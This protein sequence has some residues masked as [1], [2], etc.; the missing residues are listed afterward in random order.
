MGCSKLYLIRKWQGPL[1]KHFLLIIYK[2]SLTLLHVTVKLQVKFCVRW[3]QWYASV[4]IQFIMYMRWW[5]C[6]SCETYER[7][8]CTWAVNI[9]CFASYRSAYTNMEE[10]IDEL[11][12]EVENK[13]INKSN[14]DRSRKLQAANTSSSKSSFR[15]S[16]WVDHNSTYR[17]VEAG[18][19]RFAFSGPRLSI[20]N[21]FIRHPNIWLAASH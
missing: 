17:T 14:E 9:L 6:I 10:D 16:P 8:R 2:I 13:F 19:V 18:F 1:L 3:Q 5:W 7:S 15:Y 11:L 12:E 21:D 4:T 20:H